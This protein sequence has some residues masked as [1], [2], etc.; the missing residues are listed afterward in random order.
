LREILL[1]LR[2]LNHKI[3]LGSGCDQSE[4]DAKL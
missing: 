4:E 1:E 3:E 2:D